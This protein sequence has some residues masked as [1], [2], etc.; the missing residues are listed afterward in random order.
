MTRFV[1]E[2]GYDRCPVSDEGAHDRQFRDGVI[3]TS[4]VTRQAL[5]TSQRRE[6][7]DRIAKQLDIISENMSF[8]FRQRLGVRIQS[9]GSQLTQINGELLFGH[10]I[11]WTQTGLRRLADNAKPLLALTYAG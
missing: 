6:K 8:L 3:G 4:G 11:L 2:D 10:G 1:V 7:N 9:K 5:G